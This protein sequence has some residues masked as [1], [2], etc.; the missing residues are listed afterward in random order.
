MARVVLA[1]ILLALAGCDSPSVALLQQMDAQRLAAD[2]RVQ[3]HRSTEAVQRA[4][5]ADTDEASNGFAREAREA[6]DTLEA[7]RGAINALLADIGS[8]QEKQLAQDFGTAFS[9]LR[10][11]DRTLLPLAALNTNV[12]A[13]RLSFGPARDAADALR[14]HLERAA[15]SAPPRSAVRAQLLATRVQLS[16]REMQALQA[17]HI[18]EA[19]DAAMTRMEQQMAKSEAAAR[20]ALA[21][22]PPLLGSEGASELASAREQLD[23]FAQTQR[24]LITLSRT[25]SEVRSLAAA[26]GEKRELTA[27]CDAALIAIRDELAK[28]GSRATR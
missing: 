9:R 8:P 10:D 17:P 22:L 20:A 26:L 4:I 14:D 16:V 15:Q 21:E 5:M 1:L 25:N 6:A 3:L 12:K 2:M 23:R 19:D 18:A 13:Q 7:D 11:L 24:E 27:A 28:H